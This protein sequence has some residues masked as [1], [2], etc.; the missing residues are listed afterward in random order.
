MVSELLKLRLNQGK[1]DNLFFYRDEKGMEIDVVRDH[2][3]EIDLLEAKLAR[4]LDPVFFR[5]LKALA[6]QHGRVRASYLVYGGDGTRVQE[7]CRVTGWRDLDT[8]K[9]E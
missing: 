3:L 5:P 2:G 8:L 7:G 6:A 9:A 4:T 1:P